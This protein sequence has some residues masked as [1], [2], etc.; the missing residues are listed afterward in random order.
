MQQKDYS[1]LRIGLA[2][3]GGGSRAIAFHLGCLRALHDRGLLDKITAMSTVSGGSVIGALFAYSDKPFQEFEKDIINLLSKGLTC[4]LI[5]Y[6]ICSKNFFNI[7]FCMIFSGICALV[8]ELSNLIVFGI[9]FWFP[10]S[11]RKFFNK[12]IL[13]PPI[14]FSSR[15]KAFEQYLEDKY[16]QGK[17]LTDPTRN[18]IIVNI[19]AAE[20]RTQTV[21]NFG[22]K[23][24]ST[25]RFGELRPPILVSH[26]VAASAAYPVFLPAID[27]M[28]EFKKNQKIENPLQRVIITDGGVYDNVGTDFFIR[29]LDKE[30]DE[31]INFIIACVAGQGLPDGYSYPYSWFSRMVASIETT[32]RRTETMTFNLLHWLNKYGEIKGFIMPYLGQQDCN[33]KKPILI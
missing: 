19:N 12:L 27:E 10:N 1:D 32:H 26:A 20:L 14:R 25:W 3:S 24:S 7:L 9:K 18:N 22:S 13:R 28:L 6:I 4:G 33:L 30:N 29:R 31:K 16:F 2:L 5:R 21:F 15:T 23:K 8:F 17:H 11:F